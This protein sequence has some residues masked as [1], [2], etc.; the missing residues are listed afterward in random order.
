MRTDIGEDQR[1]A[2]FAGRGQQ[3]FIQEAGQQ[4]ERPDMSWRGQ[5]FRTKGPLPGGEENPLP[6]LVQHG[7]IPVKGTGQRGSQCMGSRIA[8]HGRMLVKW[9]NTAIFVSESH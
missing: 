6:Q 1:F 5:S 9:Q 4:V 8:N 3:G 7:R 2:L